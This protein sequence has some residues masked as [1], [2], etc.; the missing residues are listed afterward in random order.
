MHSCRIKAAF[1]TR[2]VKFF[3]V[4]KDCNIPVQLFPLP[5]LYTLN[6]YMST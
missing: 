3:N 2:F 1:D 6:A 4:C 5:I